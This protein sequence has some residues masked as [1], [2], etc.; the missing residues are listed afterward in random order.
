MESN[1][2]KLRLKLTACCFAILLTACATKQPM[3]FE[4][5]SNALAE[6]QSAS[7][8]NYPGKSPKEVLQA[9]QKVLFLLDPTYD[10]Q[11]DVSDNKLYAKRAWL[12]YV[13][14]MAAIGIDQY[15]VTVSP[16]PKGTNG[17]IAFSSASAPLVGPSNVFIKD[18]QVGANDNPADF[19]LFHDRVE[20]ILGLKNK[21]VTCDEAKASQKDPSKFMML[22]DSVGLENVA[23]ND[24]AAK[25]IK[26]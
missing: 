8:R 2:M 22:C 18:L 21:W 23:P 10:M 11:F 12:I 13:V 25:N 19:I 1:A 15:N 14:L 26:F 17:S 16:S 4:Q 20:Y 3:T 9:S 5:M 7:T 6:N 24:E